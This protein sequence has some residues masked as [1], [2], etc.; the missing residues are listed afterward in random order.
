MFIIN[1]YDRK[2][3]NCSP[4]NSCYVSD[5]ASS[6]YKN[7]KNFTTIHHHFHDHGVSTEWHFFSQATEKAPTME[8]MEQ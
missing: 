2:A 3:N 5:S 7:Y 4:W 8:L 6:Q 1:G